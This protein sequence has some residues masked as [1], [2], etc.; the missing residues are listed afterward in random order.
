MPRVVVIGS[1]NVDFTVRL[2]RL[3]RAGETVS[4]GEFYRCFG[5]KGANQAV[6]ALRAGAEVRFLAK[7]GK[8]PMGEQLRDHLEGLGLPGR[9]LLFDESA[10]T[11]TAL[12]LVDQEGKN[13]IG[14][15]PGANRTLSQEE[16][17]SC[18]D[19]FDWGELLLC[20]LEVP[21]EAVEAALSLGR[22]KGMKTLLNPA[23]VS[24]LPEKT[25][26]L[27]D[28]I[29]PNEG[30]AKSITNCENVQEAARRLSEMGP[31]QVILTLGKQGVFYLK[32]GEPCCMPS[33]RV[34]AVDTTGCGDAFNGALACALAEGRGLEEAVRFGAAA[35]AL[36]ATVKGAQ[37]AMP[38]REEIMSLMGG[39]AEK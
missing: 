7:L 12:I 36:A 31:S 11:G 21:L 26:G 25:L 28:V 6:A 32:N 10:P 22:E 29:T 37:D 1:A 35:G 3:P 8:D 5:G 17:K 27:V 33:Y 20:Q 23:P 34:R 13:L 16:V 2:P 14:V 15:A 18:A 24:P 4:G 39:K 19:L 38:F 9:Y 30:E